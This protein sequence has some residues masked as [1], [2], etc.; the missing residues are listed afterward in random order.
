MERTMSEKSPLDGF[1]W[2]QTNI[3]TK[4]YIK[5]RKDIILSL[6]LIIIQQ[7]SFFVDYW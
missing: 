4:D 7:K 6:K 1:E 3:F 5:I 2:N